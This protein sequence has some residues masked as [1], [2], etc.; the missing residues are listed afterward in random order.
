MNP[1]VIL[2]VGLVLLIATVHRSFRS[3]LSR[4]GSVEA[5]NP[6]ISW[7]R[8]VAQP[9]SAS[10]LGKVA[11]GAFSLGFSKPSHPYTVSLRCFPWDF[12]RASYPDWFTGDR[13]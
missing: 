2:V 10:G 4:Q 13:R 9:G 7:P 1:V 12:L 11:L 3:C 6:S 8:S 5:A